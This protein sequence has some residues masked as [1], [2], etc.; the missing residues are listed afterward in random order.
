MGSESGIG[1]RVCAP[2]YVHV[3]GQRR[4]ERSKLPLCQSKNL[5]IILNQRWKDT[6][7]SSHTMD[8][9]SRPEQLLHN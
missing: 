9:W 3:Q 7:S 2:L 4:K 6:K 5:I 8:Q 1:R